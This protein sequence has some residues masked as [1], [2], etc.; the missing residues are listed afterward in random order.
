MAHVYV[1]SN[2]VGAGTG[3]DWANAYTTLAAALTAKA[4][5]DNFWV[6]HNHAETAAAAKTLTSPGT[7]AAPCT[8]MCVN[9]AGSVPPVSADLRTTATISSTGANAVA[10]A[11]GWSY[12]Y[13]VTLNSGSG[14]VAVVAPV[15]SANGGWVLESCAVKN[16][17]TNSGGSIQLGSG[18]I[19]RAIHVRFKNTTIE[20][21]H[22][23]HGLATTGVDFRWENTPSAIAG[24][25]IPTSLFLN[26]SSAST[27]NVLVEGV[28]LS[29]LG[30]GKKLVDSV[31]SPKRF[32]FKDCKLDAAVTIATTPANAGSGE[33]CIINCDSGGTNYRNEKYQYMGTQT[34]ST[35]IIRT[36]GASDGTTGVSWNL[37]TTANS[38]WIIPFESMPL[39]AWNSTTASNVTATIEGVWNAA[40]LPNNDEFWIDVEYLGASTSPLG[41]FESGSKADFLAAGAALTASTEAWDSQVTARANS[42]AYSLNDVRKVATNSGRIF[43]CTTAG[44]SAGSEPAGYASA[45]DGGSVTDGTAVFRAAVRFK[46]TV[47]LS[48][49]QPAQIGVVYAYPKAAKASSTFYIDPKLTLA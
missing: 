39:T 1:D 29:A 18:T 26:T 34:V 31:N 12:M 21:G 7:A 30:S 10:C 42:T 40:A 4:A 48:S 47:T 2:A 25:T 23:N 44:T 43:F 38:K 3:A 28:D 16:L 33:V 49:P 27:G 19:P 46:Q 13:G 32:V 20:V 5:G 37:T 9:S 11:G 22:V 8:I 15:G 45:V 41:S 17:G 24:A 35:T 36:G 14:A 6:A